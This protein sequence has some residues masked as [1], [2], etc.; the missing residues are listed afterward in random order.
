MAEDIIGT[1]MIISGGRYYSEAE[2]ALRTAQDYRRAIRRKGK[3]GEEAQVSSSLPEAPGAPI[4]QFFRCSLLVNFY[5][6]PHL[7]FTGLYYAGARWP[8]D[9]APDN[10]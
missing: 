1:K 3:L 4:F 5:F 7:Y 10:T 9:L 6:L 2:L 8:G